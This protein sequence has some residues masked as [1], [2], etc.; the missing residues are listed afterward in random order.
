MC[1]RVCLCVYVCGVFGACVCVR[2]RVYVR[3]CVRVYV[4]GVVERNMFTSTVDRR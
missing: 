4:R 2:A 1:A 3:L